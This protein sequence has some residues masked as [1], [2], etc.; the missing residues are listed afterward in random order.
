MINLLMSFVVVI[1]VLTAS[2]A[3]FILLGI[4]LVLQLASLVFT[5]P[6]GIFQRA[7]TGLA[8]AA[9]GFVER[10]SARING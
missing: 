2:V 10:F 8:F 7:S 9:Q 3:S 5:V 6:S 1:I 4:G